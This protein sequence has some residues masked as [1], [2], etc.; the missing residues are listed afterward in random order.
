MAQIFILQTK[1]DCCR[2]KLAI[3]R[4]TSAVTVLPKFVSGGSSLNF[5]QVCFKQPP[6]TADIAVMTLQTRAIFLR[7]RRS[8]LFSASCTFGMSPNKAL[9]SLLANKAQA[10][11]SQKL[12][13]IPQL[14]REMTSAKTGAEA[15]RYGARGR[16]DL[17]FDYQRDV[18]GLCQPRVTCR[19][20]GQEERN[21]DYREG[22]H[23]GYSDHPPGHAQA[24][25]DRRSRSHRPARFLTVCQGDLGGRGGCTCRFI[26]GS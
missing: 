16:P 24:P 18:E 26:I 11:P 9:V 3:Q 15:I 6:V 12:T 8:I 2:L 23:Y 14:H 13:R 20:L 17:Q 19:T 7:H 1:I 10:R 4:A 25:S 21:G 5:R 22:N